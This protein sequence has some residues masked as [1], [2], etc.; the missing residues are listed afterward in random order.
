MSEPDRYRP[1]RARDSEA[2][3]VVDAVTNTAVFR[4]FNEDV[5]WIDAAERNRFIRFSR[6]TLRDASDFDA[7]CADYLPDVR[8][9]FTANMDRERQEALLLDRAPRRVL[10]AA[11]GT[12]SP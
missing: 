2:F 6:T 11:Q 8:R 7:F 3:V 4:A 5:A 10:L 12:R 1:V 9:L